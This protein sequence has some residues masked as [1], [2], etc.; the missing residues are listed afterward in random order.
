MPEW[1]RRLVELG[2]EPTDGADEASY[3]AW[4]FWDEHV[5]GL[6]PADSPEGQAIIAPIR[7]KAQRE[8]D[9]RE[10]QRRRELEREIRRARA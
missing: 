6:P 5:P 9:Q 7:A 8:R 2:E 4:L 3:C 10:R 1:A